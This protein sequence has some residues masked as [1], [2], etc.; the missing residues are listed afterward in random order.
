MRTSGVSVLLILLG[1]TACNGDSGTTDGGSESAV[2]DFS[3]GGANVV[4][5]T[6]SA[7]PSETSSTFNIPYTSL[8]VCVAGTSTCTT[9][10]DVLVD[11]GSSGLRLMASALSALTLAEQSDPNAAGNIIA[12]CLPFADGYTWGAVATADVKIGQESAS[13]VPINIIDDNASFAPAVPAS[14]SSNGTSLNSVNDFGANGV[15]GVGLF[16]QDCG[17]GC[18][19]TASYDLYYSCDTSACVP[20]TEALASQVVNPVALFATDNNGV[21]L[22]LPTIP[23]AGAASATGYLVFGIGT[24]SNNALGSATVLTTNPDTGT[25]ITEFNGESLANSFIDSGSNGLYFPDSAI[26]TCTGSA[27][28]AQFYCPTF[29]MVL[30]ATNEGENGTTSTVAFDLANLND[31]RQSYFAFDDVGG[32][33]TAITGLGTDYFDFGLPFFY[34]RTV[35]TAIDGMSAGSATGPYVAY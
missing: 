1:L 32:D 8:T 21:I 23:D 24:E 18:A 6:V 35:F 14:C 16:G 12:E 17:S 9:I 7:G 25:F 5:V 33:A 28:A 31:L 30:S 3:A 27:E 15:L 19:E 34:G 26:A 20:T 11:T 2:H 10:N 13:A 29:T 22:Q 4:A